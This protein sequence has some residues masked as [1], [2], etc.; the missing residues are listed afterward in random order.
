MSRRFRGT[1]QADPLGIPDQ[2]LDHPSYCPLP[3]ACSA[4]MVLRNTPRQVVDS[5]AATELEPLE[6][7]RKAQRWVYPLET[8]AGIAVVRMVA[9]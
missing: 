7:A 6:Q 9:E 5:I 1:F 4:M 3:V 8:T 2:R